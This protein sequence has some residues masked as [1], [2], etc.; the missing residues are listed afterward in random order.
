MHPPQVG[1]SSLDLRTA[2]FGAAAQQ[3]VGLRSSSDLLPL[4]PAATSAAQH[5]DR[6]ASETAVA[7]LEDDGLLLER[8]RA[9]FEQV[10]A[11]WWGWG[12]LGEE[13]MGAE[14]RFWMDKMRRMSTRLKDES[15][16]VRSISICGVVC[17]TSA[18]RI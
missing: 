3:P 7:V 10:G 6:A 4:P 1:S 2:P 11:V 13:G 14:E 8:Q 16:R 5:S 9:A 17:L 15:F 12:G 18:R